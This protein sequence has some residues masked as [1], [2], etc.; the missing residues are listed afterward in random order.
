M[1]ESLTKSLHKLLQ[2]INKV[3]Q[4]INM[5]IDYHTIA[6]CKIRMPTKFNEGITQIPLQILCN[7][8]KTIT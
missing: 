3:I 7:Q 5:P 2:T 8:V 1:A 6:N 4:I